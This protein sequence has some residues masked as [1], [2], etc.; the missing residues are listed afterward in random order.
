MAT[1]H[2]DERGVAGVEG[3]CDR[4]AMRITH[5]VGADARRVCPV[6]TG[7]L[8]ES[9]HDE[10]HAV[11]VG[12]VYVG[13][14]HWAPTEYGSRPHDMRARTPNGVLHFFWERE[15]RDVFFRS[16]HH[17]GT[18]EQSFMRVALYTVRVL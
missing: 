8:K 17:P 11:G 18:P 10:H 6:D 4:L 3:E 13:T 7:E 14:D 1:V 16:V 2:M 12:R 9:I 5:D 15:G